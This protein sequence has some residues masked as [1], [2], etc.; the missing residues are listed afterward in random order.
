[1]KHW[2]AK[3][4]LIL[5]TIHFSL[6]VASSQTWQECHDSTFHY[7]H[8]GVHQKTVEWGVKALEYDIND[9]TVKVKNQLNLIG[10]VNVSYQTLKDIQNAT[11]PSE[12][13]I[14]KELAI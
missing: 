12:N 14:E 3:T 8:K 2:H 10:A 4:I 6:L 1:M 7:F 11:H 5:I 13:R 9:T